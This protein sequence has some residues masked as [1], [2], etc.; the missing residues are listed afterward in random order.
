MKT[1]KVFLLLIVSLQFGCRKP[2]NNEIDSIK[3]YTIGDSTM[4][5][6]PDPDK[7]PER[8]WVQ[9][10]PPFFNENVSI[11][12]HAINGR[13]SKSFKEEGH[14]KP[15]LEKIQKGDYVFIQFGHNDAKIYDPKRFTNP[16][17]AY[18][19]NLI[20]YV[21]EAQEKGANPILFTSI[22]RR[23]FNENGV[24]VD[25]HGDYTLVT[26]LVAQEMNVPLI[27]LQYYSELL[28]LKYGV[29]DSKKLHLHFKKGENAYFQDEKSD[30]TH[31][32]ILGANEIAK[33][34]ATQLKLK[35]KALENH[36]K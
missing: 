16:H 23:N 17:T 33:I 35:V 25:T 3:I 32:S 31:L 2:A 29:E 26:R 28:E 11:E 36:L 7:N 21:K 20:Q 4:A 34:A 18:R 15:V 14:W 12:N 22:V 13:S 10:L 27:D 6:K 19:N 1:L 8:G 5:N 30:D 9:M 24:L